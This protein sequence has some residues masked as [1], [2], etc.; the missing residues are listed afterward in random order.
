ML[1]LEALIWHG[2]RH[3]WAERGQP[4]PVQRIFG[5]PAAARIP[6]D[7]ETGQFR[8]GDYGDVLVDDEGVRWR[9]NPG[10]LVLTMVED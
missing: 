10:S 4:F 7:P 9:R 5:E 8:A 1:H 6:I 2:V 3:V